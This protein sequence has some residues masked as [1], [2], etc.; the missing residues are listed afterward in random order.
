MFKGNNKNN[1]TTYV[2]R[3]RSGVSIINREHISHLF[4]VFLNVDF[5]Q[6]NVTLVSSSM[7]SICLY[8]NKEIEDTI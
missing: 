3:H 7:C 4:L 5:E 1:R 2:V 8:M 6:V